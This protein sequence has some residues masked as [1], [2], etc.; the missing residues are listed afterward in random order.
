MG[1]QRGRAQGGFV[2]ATRSRPRGQ[3]GYPGT[4][5]G[6]SRGASVAATRYD[7][8]FSM[9]YD[10]TPGRTVD[11]AEYMNRL[12]RVQNTLDEVRA[13]QLSSAPA[14]P[15]AAALEKKEAQ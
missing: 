1:A 7:P 2:P 5:A 14:T 15:A 9:S 11:H 10:T 3:A 8:G 6:I 13:F 4:P 12:S